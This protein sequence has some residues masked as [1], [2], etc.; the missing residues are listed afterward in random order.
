LNL[1]NQILK[2]DQI[3]TEDS[4]DLL[5]TLQ[6]ALDIAG[7]EP[8]IGTGADALNSIISGFRAAQSKTSDEKKK[9]LINAGI[10]A[11]SMIP[12]ADVVKLL[13]NKPARKL[14]VKG[15][16]MIKNSVKAAKTPQ[17]F[18]YDETNA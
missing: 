13:K 4:Q 2:H 5:N 10:S 1:Y 15:A 11:I 9:H 17:R 3:I 18:N 8:T 14:A 12:F 6:T 16:R 7:L